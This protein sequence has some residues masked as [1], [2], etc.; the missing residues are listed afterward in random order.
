M[1]QTATEQPAGTAEAAGMT[2]LREALVGVRYGEV[3]AVIHDGKIVEVKET[4]RHRP[5]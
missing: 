5:E 2:M 4:R 3:V 1:A